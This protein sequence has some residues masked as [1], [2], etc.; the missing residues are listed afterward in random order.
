MTNPNLQGGTI[1][2]SDNAAVTAAI[3][4]YRDRALSIVKDKNPMIPRE[5]MHPW[6]KDFSSDGTICIIELEGDHKPIP[7]ANAT[8]LIDYMEDTPKDGSERRTNR[9]VILLQDMSADVVEHLGVM[10]NIPPHFFLA[11]CDEISDLRV[12]DSTYAAQ[13]TNYW[14]IPVPRR[15]VVPEGHEN[16]DGQYNVTAG[17]IPR[18]TSKMSFSRQIELRNYISYWGRNYGPDSWTAVILMDSFDTWLRSPPAPSQG[19]DEVE[20]LLLEPPQPDTLPSNRSILY[21]IMIAGD[22]KFETITQ[23]VHRNILEAAVTGY[24][25]FPP[26]HN[27]DPFTGTMVIRNLIR[28]AWE[29]KVIYDAQEFRKELKDDRQNYQKRHD[30]IF[31]TGRAARES[32]SSMMTRRQQIQETRRKLV[33][34]MWK[35][36]CMYADEPSYAK[37]LSTMPDQPHVARLQK[38]LTEERRAWKILYEIQRDLESNAA[39]HMDMWS[40]RAAFGQTE[41]ENEQ[42]NIANEHT[43]IANEQTNIANEQA[44][45]A[46]KLARTSGHLTMFATIIVPSTFV[47]SIFSMN[48]DF[49]AG[50]N[51]FYI[52]WAISVPI[53]IT[54]FLIVLRHGILDALRKARKV[55]VFKRHMTKEETPQEF[56]LI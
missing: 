53:T 7:F 24:E 22:N 1:H 55:F 21:E 3:A 16:P 52:Y 18:E 33:S 34:I 20:P 43:K 12:I 4:V 30:D 25:Q 27:E 9:R 6:Y 32:Y 14:K 48:G 38:Y 13:N 44:A 45:A 5:T 39:E 15:Y 19:G 31:E 28:S 11:H 23:P 41:I 49:E 51:N 29:E 8:E 10:L 50:K 37:S 47:A 42:T 17:S 54:I 35:F 46:N 56:E 26:P 36:R 2:W 40:Q